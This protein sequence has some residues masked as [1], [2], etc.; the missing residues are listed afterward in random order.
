MKRP[1]DRR[2]VAV[3]FRITRKE[4][5][6]LFLPAVERVAREHGLPE[7]GR[8]MHAFLRLL[9]VER[10]VRRMAEG[11]V[12]RLAREALLVASARD[13]TDEIERLKVELEAA[14]RKVDELLAARAGALRELGEAERV[15]EALASRVAATGKELGR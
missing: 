10:D 2:A 14:R 7:H 3:T 1:R 5:D 11:E 13:Q 8:R 9:R 4:H 15:V 6:E 12:E